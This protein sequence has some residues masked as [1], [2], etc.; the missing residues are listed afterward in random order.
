ML[1]FYHACS[2]TWPVRPAWAWRSDHHDHGS[3]S[4]SGFGRLNGVCDWALARRAEEMVSNRR[5]RHAHR[6]ENVSLRHHGREP[7]LSRFLPRLWLVARRCD[8]A[9]IG[10]A[11]ATRCARP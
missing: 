5:D 4:E 8:A 7:I 11:V 1:V 6:D 2:I 10:L 9:A 3:A